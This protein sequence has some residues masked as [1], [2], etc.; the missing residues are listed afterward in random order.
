MINFYTQEEFEAQVE[1]LVSKGYSQ[2]AA[3]KV[4]SLRET[5]EAQRYADWVD[6]QME[7]REIYAEFG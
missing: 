3:I 4:V 1:E 2:V 6:S 7:E 5:E